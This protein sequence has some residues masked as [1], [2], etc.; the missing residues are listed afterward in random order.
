MSGDSLLSIYG[1]DTT[2]L[3]NHP[4]PV[5][6]EMTIPTDI[7][8]W[9]A[10]GNRAWNSNLGGQT[11]YNVYDGGYDP[12]TYYLAHNP[13][14]M[15]ADPMLTSFNQNSG[16]APIYIQVYAESFAK[17]LAGLEV[18][19]NSAID[20]QD[21]N[22]NQK[23]Q[24]QSKLDAVEDLKEKINA[25]INNCAPA[26][27]LKKLKEELK[28][29]A[30]SIS[31]L[32][33][34][35]SEDLISA[36][37]SQ[38]DA[39]EDGQELP[40]EEGEVDDEPTATSASD[41]KDVAASVTSLI[42]DSIDGPG[43][44]NKQLKNLFGNEEFVNKDT[45]VAIFDDWKANYESEHGALTDYIYNDHFW[46]NGGNK[47][48]AKIAECFEEKARELGIYSKVAK[49]L[50]K[51]KGELDAF[52]NT[53]ESKVKEYINNVYTKLK[54]EMDEKEVKA[55]EADEMKKAEAQKAQQEKEWAEAKKVQEKENQFLNDMREIFKD[56]EA[57][58]SDNVKYV[59]G[60]FTIRIECRDFFG[61]D[62]KE[63]KKN[64]EN[65]SY[66]AEKYLK[67]QKLR[68]VA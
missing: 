22:D 23:A 55:R 51:I 36:A 46:Y 66:D 14:L 60:Q 21:L 25:A 65:A 41:I 47:Y 12:M 64:I 19:L 5:G 57:E 33:Q 4:A 11:Q 48:I 28:E 31:T 68:A 37:Q 3:I 7:W 27:E 24:L 29:L 44:K 13:W 9:S 15:Q 32:V 61:K 52:W 38:A 1:I 18:N 34:G 43:T 8:S 56:D 17:S 49:D 53:K 6:Y 67:K 16:K 40:E 63:L 42:Y 50:I 30:S 54:A 20:T 59:D 62:F 10:L 58:V 39:A 45:I 2:R 26:T 35:I